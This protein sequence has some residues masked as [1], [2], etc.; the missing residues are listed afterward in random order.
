MEIIEIQRPS[1]LFK[2]TYPLAIRLWHWITFITFFFSIMLV[3]FASTLF[4]TRGNIPMVQQQV[5]AKGGMITPDQ[6]KAVSH[7]Y[8]DK[9]WML[10]KYVGFGLCFL[11]L[12]RIIIELSYSKEKRLSGKIRDA[13][14][15]SAKSEQQTNDR[16]HF[17]MVKWGYIIFYVLFL[18]MCL[19][20]LGLAFEDVPF[21]RANGKLFGNVHSIIQYLLYAYILF[22][23]AGVIRSDLTNNRG[24]VS[25]MINGGEKGQAVKS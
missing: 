9:L 25:S 24:I 16:R 18:C 5:Q 14:N 2:T 8:S 19:T 1:S 7:E 11:L 12:L 3:L 23:I 20:G 6:A 4:T 21:F 13:L 17:I 10:H 22:H 15:F